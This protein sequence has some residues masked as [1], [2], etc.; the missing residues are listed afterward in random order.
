MID[1]LLLT[2]ALLAPPLA[3]PAQVK[4]VETWTEAAARFH[5]LMSARSSTPRALVKIETLM[6]VKRNIEDLHLDDLGF[7]TLDLRPDTPLVS[8]PSANERP[9]LTI[10]PTIKAS[11][12]L[13]ALKT[14]HQAGHTR[15]ALIVKSSGAPALPT[16]LNPA[17]TA[18]VREALAGKKRPGQR[19]LPRKSEI[20]KAIVLAVAGCEDLEMMMGAL[21]DPAIPPPLRAEMLMRG[22][23]MAAKVCPA[24][25]VFDFTAVLTAVISEDMSVGIELTLDPKAKPLVVSKD[26]TWQSF[27]DAV[28]KHQGPFWLAVK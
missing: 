10:A 24:K 1:L 14:I 27:V 3:T 6:P 15:I 26:A 18:K 5:P 4:Q 23:R 2:A 25:P 17:L 16:S 13:D 12:I 7:R 20:T 8:P 19:R 9:L 11:Q 22:T 21:S 28:A